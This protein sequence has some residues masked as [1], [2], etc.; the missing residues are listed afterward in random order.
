M[1]APLRTASI[2][3]ALG[4]IGA[5]LAGCS[6]PT[7]LF[8]STGSGE[9]GAPV[10]TLAEVDTD[11]PEAGPELV[12]PMVAMVEASG[13]EGPGDFGAAI[14]IG[15]SPE[16]IRLI[17][18]RHV[19]TTGRDL[20]SRQLRVYRDIGVRFW[21]DSERSHRAR[22]Q[23]LDE[24]LDLA[25]VLVPDTE[26]LRQSLQK[27]PFDLEIVLRRVRSPLALQR[28]DGLFTIGNPNEIP[29]Y[30]APFDPDRVLTVTDDAIEFRSGFIAKGHSGG[31]LF[32]QDWY[33]VGMITHDRPPGGRALR[34]DRILER[35]HERSVVADLATP[36]PPPETAP[37]FRDCDDI[38]TITLVHDN[39]PL[40]VDARVCPEM[41]ALPGGEFQ[42]GARADEKGKSIY[43]EEP[44][45]L[46][47]VP[48]FAIGTH[49]VTIAEYQF[50]MEET[51]R[52]AA[53]GC[54]VWNKGSWE[55]AGNKNWRDPGFP[56]D[57]R[58][59]VVCVSWPEAEAYAAWLSERT[60]ER[61]RL[62]TEAE[63]EYA[64]R[65]G[66]A[67]RFWWGDHLAEGK[68]NC[69]NCGRLWDANT[70]APVGRFEPNF[71]GLHDMSGNVWE[72]VADCWHKSYAG[73]PETGAPWTD[74]GGEGA[75]PS[76]CSRRVQRGGAWLERA[77]TLRSANRLQ[78]SAKNRKSSVGFRVARDL[79]PDQGDRLAT[80]STSSPKKH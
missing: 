55:D 45:H 27:L 12:G 78:D 57:H 52:I 62:P 7:D 63:W 32:S 21:F 41:A 65:A 68:A 36:V 80:V 17:T 79:A 3:A 58:S 19:V 4:L 38:R 18:A 60:G 44:R 9:P 1:N 49:E 50:F 61:Y 33:L 5:A 59:P 11:V 51:G 73:A 35:L 30:S 39:K 67:T 6:F 72:W 29:W 26:A 10:L 66:T 42:M 20:R 43:N 8:D 31:A 22:P 76:D 77:E 69:L 13:D 53:Q 37:A 15:R 54:E 71:F 74:Q 56:Q 23:M 34:I 25:V 40:A 70:P 14:L 24:N 75:E 28:H 2:S 48:P 47:S 16:G 46:V 64:A